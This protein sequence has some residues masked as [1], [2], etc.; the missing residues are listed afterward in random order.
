[1]CFSFYPSSTMHYTTLV[2]QTARSL[3]WWPAKWF[4]CYTPSR[5][6]G[7]LW[8]TALDTKVMF[9]LPTSTNILEKETRTGFKVLQVCSSFDYIAKR[10]LTLFLVSP[11]SWII[12]FIALF[13][14]LSLLVSFTS[15]ILPSTA[16]SSSIPIAF[17]LFPLCR[18]YS[19]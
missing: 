16:F 4:S 18:A 3:T 13:L 1:M 8:K 15:S 11:F 17:C 5:L 10:L 6:I 14:S 7:G 9:L 19:P 12:S 2:A